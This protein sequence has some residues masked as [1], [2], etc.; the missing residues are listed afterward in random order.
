MVYIMSTLQATSTAQL[1][2]PFPEFSELH[3]TPQS[4]QWWKSQKRLGRK[5]IRDR[6]MHEVR[7]APYQLSRPCTARSLRSS[8]KPWLLQTERKEVKVSFGGCCKRRCSWCL[9][10]QLHGLQTSLPVR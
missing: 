5:G 8:M 2:D 7:V 4:T 3:V 6:G 1:Y 9:Q 10:V